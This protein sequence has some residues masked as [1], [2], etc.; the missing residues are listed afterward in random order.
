MKFT[1][2][3]FRITLF[4][5]LILISDGCNRNKD[6]VNKNCLVTKIISDD[7]TATITYD[8]QDRISL[9]TVQVGPDQSR[10]IN[11]SYATNGTATI[12]ETDEF[13][14]EYVYTV[15]VN[16][17]GQVT[18]MDGGAY[19]LDFTYTGTSDFF[20]TADGNAVTWS[21]GN[22]TRIEDDYGTY[23]MTYDNT[24]NPYF[25]NYPL[26][27]KSDLIGMAYF[28]VFSK[29]NITGGSLTLKNPDPGLAGAI[30]WTQTYTYNDFFL[31]T[32]VI[33]T[34]TIPYQDQAPEVVTVTTSFEYA[35]K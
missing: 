11:V 18:G 25:E 26:L 35:C 7:Q 28:A 23:E 34:A 5:I 9:I 3:I 21:N 8:D 22:I 1:N 16:A 27:F 10:T 29:N 4:S 14:D 20:T 32:S 33:F 6:S 13:N 2:L 12:V 19:T 17:N 30:T 15:S 24:N 31:P